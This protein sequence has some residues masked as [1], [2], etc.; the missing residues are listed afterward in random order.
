VKVQAHGGA[1]LV[2][3]TV[4]WVAIERLKCE[5]SSLGC[6]RGD[7]RGFRDAQGDPEV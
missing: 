2:V 5:I 1:G 3:L 4:L 6:V 7:D